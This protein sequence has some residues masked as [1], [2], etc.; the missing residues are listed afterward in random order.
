MTT[1]LYIIRPHVIGEVDICNKQGKGA[2]CMH[3]RQGKGMYEKCKVDACPLE[4]KIDI[5]NEKEN[6]M[7]R[8]QHVPVTIK[9]ESKVI[10]K[11]KMKCSLCHVL[12]TGCISTSSSRKA[13]KKRG[14]Q[15]M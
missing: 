8:Q 5:G 15:H 12:S 4:V 7:C 14:V 6:D 1:S 2:S 9:G 10:D 11:S 13:R 3:E